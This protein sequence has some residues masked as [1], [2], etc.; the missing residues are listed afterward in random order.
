VADEGL[1]SDELITHLMAVGQ[2][3]ILVGVPT[4][5]NAS[6]VGGLVRAVHHGFARYF[7]RE[8]TVLIN[9]DGGSTDGTPAAV[10]EASLEADDTLTVSHR[11]RTVHR[12]TTPYHGL[13]GKGDAIHRIFAAAELLQAKAVAILD[14]EVA[15]VTP[16]WVAALVRPVVANGFDFVAPLY[17]RHPCEGPLVTQLVRPL[18]RAAYGWQIAE[19]LVGEFGCSSRFITRC[20][21]E[22]VWEG[23]LADF[24]ID[25]W[26]AG[27]AMSGGF[28]FCQAPLGPRML[29][30]GASRPG[31]PDVFRQV[32]GSV[33]TCLQMHAPYWRTRNGSEALP[34]SGEIVPTRTEAPVPEGGK[35]VQAFCQDLQHIRPVLEQLLSPETLSEL[36]RITEAD[37]LDVRYPDDLWVETVY[38]CMLAYHR[39]PLSRQHITQALL[40]LYLGRAGS[41]LLECGSDAAVA[42]AKL[43]ALAQAFE[44]R[45]PSLVERWNHV[46]TR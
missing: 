35:L 44:A 5:N 37:C 40:P 19:P 8:R 15:S 2:V 43:E 3:D 12:I 32:A 27:M 6:T 22:P 24:T 23:N 26:L 30:T 4:F 33:F 31:L 34:L 28:R 13:R 7:L 36:Y 14:P 1:L 41:F 10:R 42:E 38:E 21:E 20:L 45:K 11:L 29:G 25:P 17:P 16:E 46:V 18:V 39:A 9:S